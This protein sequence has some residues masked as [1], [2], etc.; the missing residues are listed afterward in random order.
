[1]SFLV[2]IGCVRFARYCGKI[3]TRRQ[4]FSVVDY[5]IVT[6]IPKKSLSTITAGKDST[7]NQSELETAKR[8][9]NTCEQVSVGT[10]L[11]WILFL[12]KLLV[13]KMARVLPTNHSV[14]KSK[15]KPIANNF[16]HSI[17][18]FNSGQNGPHSIIEI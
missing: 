8:G 1:M 18:Y 2:P 15:I 17:D 12:I 13:H 3:N 9:K 14:Q 16:R 5:N 10:A 4:S 11:V 6:R 7:I